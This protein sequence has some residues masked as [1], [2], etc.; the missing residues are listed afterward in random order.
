[1]VAWAIDLEFWQMRALGIVQIGLVSLVRQGEELAL[2]ES[3]S[4]LVQPDDLDVYNARSKKV[5]GLERADLQ[6]APGF[7]VVWGEVLKTLGGSS[8]LIAHNGA[9]C[10]RTMLEKSA[11][12]CRIDLSPL[13]IIDTLKVAKSV[14]DR[15]KNLVENEPEVLERL[16]RDDAAKLHQWAGLKSWRL[17]ALAP[18]VGRRQGGIHDARDDAEICAA[19]AVEMDGLYRRMMGAGARS[20]VTVSATPLDSGRHPY[21]PGLVGWPWFV[22][23]LKP[24]KVMSLRQAHDFAEIDRG[25]GVPDAPPASAVTTLEKDLSKHR[26]KGSEGR[27]IGGVVDVLSRLLPDGHIGASPIGSNRIHCQTNHDF[28][29]TELGLG[30]E[31]ERWSVI[32]EQDQRIASSSGPQPDLVVGSG[33]WFPVELDRSQRSEAE[34]RKKCAA[35]LRRTC[36][37]PDPGPDAPWGRY[38]GVVFVILT[39]KTNRT[40]SLARGLLKSFEDLELPPTVCD[41]MNVLYPIP[42]DL[43]GF[44]PSAQSLARELRGIFNYGGSEAIHELSRRIALELNR[45]STLVYNVTEPDP[46]W[47]GYV[48]YR[49]RQV[50]KRLDAHGKKQTI[51]VDA[52]GGVRFPSVVLSGTVDTTAWSEGNDMLFDLKLRLPYGQREI[53]ARLRCRHV[54]GVAWRDKRG[55]QLPDP[56]RRILARG[57]LQAAET[58]SG[59]V[60]L[61]LQALR[62]NPTMFADISQTAGEGATSS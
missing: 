57:I 62:R 45:V 61:H 34:I 8:L 17:A 36:F 1:M 60:E 41:T 31:L 37:A 11:A 14:T 49:D 19:L 53:E 30:F 21:L 44:S 10:E 58:G 18:L 59:P 20:C 35:Y 46:T 3:R 43:P 15:A 23:R 27:R 33:H 25:N 42:D 50:P 29:V 24:T 4:W 32:Y 22:R 39:R 12:A 2:G 28:L 51:E 7:E 55:Y 9:S 13:R 26:R 52:A 6:D 47:E 38:L 56:G 16:E 54:G 48:A 40:D 5:S